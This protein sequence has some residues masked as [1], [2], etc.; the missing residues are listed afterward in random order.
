MAGDDSRRHPPRP[1]SVT[2][3]IADIDVMTACGITRD[4]TWWCECGIRIDGRAR[5]VRP[6]DVCQHLRTYGMT[7]RS[8][9]GGSAG[10]EAQQ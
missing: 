6:A 7:K 10:A 3:L 2:A 9:P 4:R 1:K 8:Q 5:Y